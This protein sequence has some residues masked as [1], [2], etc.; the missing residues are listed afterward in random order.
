MDN[1][2]LNNGFNTDN[3]FQTD[4]NKF[5]M[6]YKASAEQYT[7]QQNSIDQFG[8]SNTN[9]PNTTTEPNQSPFN[10]EGSVT[11]NAPY[12]YNIPAGDYNP[13]YAPE[14]PKFGW[15]WGAFMFNALWGIGNNAY[16]ALICFIPYI[17]IIWSFVCGA[18]GNKWAWES[19]RFRNA[20]EFNAAQATWNKAGFVAF[21]VTCIVFVI[22][23]IIIAVALAG[24]FK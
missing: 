19:G 1:E 5:D 22:Y 6:N 3:K 8:A 15:N 10:P 21:I 13:Y 16:L 20:A 7:A 11:N 23:A 14:E 18:S 12:G 4:P 17:G 9:L 2:N 24:Y